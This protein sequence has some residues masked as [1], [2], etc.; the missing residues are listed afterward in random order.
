[1]RVPEG[2]PLFIDPFDLALAMV[3]G[4]ATGSD[5]HDWDEAPDGYRRCTRCFRHAEAT[6]PVPPACCLSY[7]SDWSA[8]GPVIET[9]GIEIAFKSE[10]PQRWIAADRFSRRDGDAGDHRSAEAATPALA[11][12][13]LILENPDRV[14]RWRGDVEETARFTGGESAG[15]ATSDVVKA[16]RSVPGIDLVD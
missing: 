7:G 15:G 2:S 4:V 8:I 3:L 10:M 14:A 5:L 16:L 6:G 12:R 13:A 11:V 1:M 9:L